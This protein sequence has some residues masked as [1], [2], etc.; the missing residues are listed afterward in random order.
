MDKKHTESTMGTLEKWEDS[1]GHGG[2]KK[3][4]HCAQIWAKKLF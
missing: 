1:D 2:L 3:E 4:A